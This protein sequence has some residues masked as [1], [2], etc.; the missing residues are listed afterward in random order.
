MAIL[1]GTLGVA[2]AA[3]SIWLGV[4][5]FNRRERWAKRTA[6]ALLCLPVVYALSFGPACWMTAAPRQP[7]TAD[8]PRFWMRFY[9]PI[10]AVI[11]RTQSQNAACVRLWVTWGAKQG[12]RV[13]V[14]V[15]A[16]GV[17]WYG[18]MAE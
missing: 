7:G 17:S 6:T 5:I 14:P 3:L 13:I 4:R 18:F 10:G 15:D 16:E 8:E 9:F 11:H 12:A 2:L 1:F